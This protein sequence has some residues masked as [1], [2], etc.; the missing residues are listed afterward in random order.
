MTLVSNFMIF[1]LLFIFSR[2][3]F[4]F[5]YNFCCSFV[6]NITFLFLELIIFIT[7]SLKYS[8]NVFM[9]SL[10]LYIL[11]LFF[12]KSDG[13]CSPTFFLDDFSGLFSH[14]SIFSTKHARSA[15]IING[16][17]SD[18][19]YSLNSILVLQTASQY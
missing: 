2:F 18:F 4:K 16:A 11:C 19:W 3:I 7:C 13:I 14:P 17:S 9:Q 5:S 10:P 15:Y 12:E 6:D 8:Q 1:T